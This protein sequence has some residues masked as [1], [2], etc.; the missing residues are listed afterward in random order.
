MELG[1]LV[2]SQIYLEAAWPNVK[3]E[4]DGDKAP[5][6]G[7][8][9]GNTTGACPDCGSIHKEIFEFTRWTDRKRRGKEWESL[10][11]P[12]VERWGNFVALHV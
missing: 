6:G 11:K 2:R 10:V 5:S 8:K 3:C 4:D 12:V 9:A 1:D 7:T